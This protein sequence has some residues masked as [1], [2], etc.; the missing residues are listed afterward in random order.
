[1]PFHHVLIALDDSALAAHAAEVGTNLARALNA[2][3]AVVYV[4]DPKLAYLPDGGV[5]VADMLSALKREG[6]AFLSAS[7]Q[8][9]GEPPPW[10]FLKEGTPA[11]EI[12]AAAR[13]W[14]ADLI[15]IGTHGRSGV[16]TPRAREHG[17]VSRAARTVP[18]GGG[19]SGHGTTG[20]KRADR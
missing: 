1:M 17:R 6:Q 7:A 3:A 15:V 2:Q 13:E 20:L 5:P 12:V 10:Q 9:L 11:D 4:V 14:E 16:C 8:R 18:G 19:Q